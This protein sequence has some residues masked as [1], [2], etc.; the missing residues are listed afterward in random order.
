MSVSPRTWTSVR[1]EGPDTLN[2]FARVLGE[3]FGG[4]L[5]VHRTWLD[6]VGA[7]RLRVAHDASGECVGGLGVLHVGMWVGGRPVSC[8][9]I[10]AVAVAP[11]ARGT[12]LAKALVGEALR[13]AHAAGVAL[14]ALY[15]ATIS[16]YR[17]VGY[18]QAGLRMQT[19]VPLQSLGPLSQA[20]RDLPVRRALP[21]D[22]PTIEALYDRVAAR[23]DGWL[24][25]DD[26][27]WSRVSRPRLGVAERYLIGP[28]D[29]PPEGHLGI[30]RVARADGLFHDLVLTDVTLETPR[31]LARF[32]SFLASHASLAVD[33]VLP[34]DP[35]RAVLG[36]LPEPSFHS[37]VSDAWMLRLLDLEAALTQRGW[38]PG[39]RGTLALELED[40][41]IPEN[42][43]RWQLTVEEG[44]ARL[45][46]GG[47]GG[48]ALDM[49][50]LASLYT[51]F[52]DVWT[53]A[54]LGRAQ[55]RDPATVEVAR[56][57]FSG[58]TFHMPDRF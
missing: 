50:G 30:Q 41:L 58:P 35:A 44:Q 16:V 25:R 42:R 3:S 10:S 40:P 11:H 32:W 17:A 9:G 7:D 52:R 47:D 46:R 29:A 12:G 28:A 38:R 51:G 49:P 31:A 27:L 55:V 53:L 26:Y 6:R 13:E 39:A 2:A 14:S 24:R 1:P 37:S 5:E 33:A 48:L 43:G 36:L 15:P 57:L 45:E 4:D 56:T 8:A 19:R 20:Q 23:H 22:R 54:Q 34:L 21:E 18:G